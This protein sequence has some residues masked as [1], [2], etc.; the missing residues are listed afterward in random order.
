VVQ[1]TRRLLVTTAP[2]ALVVLAGFAARG[3][4]TPASGPDTAML[5]LPAPWVASSL[6]VAAA[7]SWVFVLVSLVLLPRTSRWIASRWI[8]L[9]A[10]LLTMFMACRL[11]IARVRRVTHERDLPAVGRVAV[12][13]ERELLGHIER[14]SRVRSSGLV[15]T[16]YDVFGSAHFGSPG[17]DPYASVIRPAGSVASGE[18][19]FAGADGLVVLAA[20][21]RCYLAGRPDAPGRPNDGLLR[22]VSPFVL[23]DDATAGESREL[24]EVCAAVARASVGASGVPT[25]RDGFGVPP[26]TSLL[27][28]LDSPNAWIRSAAKRIV[29]AGGDAMYPEATKRLAAAPK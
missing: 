1:A 9:L 22:D 25:A 23:L 24:D 12:V 10:L 16:E 29:E 2:V 17:D 7:A 20:G 18:S 11:P 4:A 8:T 27:A 3:C 26:E 21:G 28:A 13:Y 14:L 5:T 6:V 19:L 15:Q